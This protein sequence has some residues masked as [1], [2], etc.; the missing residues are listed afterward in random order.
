[1]PALTRGQKILAAVAVL[2]VALYVT[3]VA[4]A[5][6]G[7]MTDPTDNALVQQ[8]GDWFGD[9]DPVD[10]ADLSAPCLTDGVLVI[11]AGCVL[12]VA[13]ADSDLREVELRPDGPLR[14]LTRAPHDDTILDRDVPAGEPIRVAVDDQGVD[15]SLTC[16]KCTVTLGGSD[17]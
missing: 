14:L 12:T 15:I 10:P 7:T 4:T 3:G 13:P 6:D 2:I 8:L 17:G 9:P 11:E 1:M 16:D 5:D